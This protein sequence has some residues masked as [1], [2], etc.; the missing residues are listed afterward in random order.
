MTIR[1]GEPWGAAVPADPARPVLTDDSAL[2]RWVNQHRH[3]GTPVAPASLLG[4]DLARTCGGGHAATVGVTVTRVTLDIVRVEMAE[5]TAWMTSHLIARRDWWRGGVAMAM[6]AQFL[7]AY[8]VTPRSH[9]NDGRVDIVEVD[10]SMSVRARLQAR[11]RARSG[12]H[13][14]HPLLR[15]RSVRDTELS[16]PRA[17]EVVID[18]IPYG[19]TDHLRLVVEPDAY[20]LDIC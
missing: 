9:P 1:K 17:L 7:G 13:L 16:F 5:R 10:P 19:S 12:S 6:N 8:D 18:G 4:G 11:S 15:T 2:H 3:A 14:P 20:E